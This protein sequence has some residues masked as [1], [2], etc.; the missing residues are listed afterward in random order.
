VNRIYFAGKR[1][2]QCWHDAQPIDFADIFDAAIVEP[3]NDC[4]AP[5]ESGDGWEHTFIERNKLP[6][7]LTLDD[8]REA[9]GWVRSHRDGGLI[10]VDPAVVKKQWMGEYS[11]ASGEHRQVYEERIAAVR[12][13]AVKQLVKWYTDGYE[14]WRVCCNFMDETASLGMIQDDYDGAHLKACRVEMAE[15][16]ADLLEKRGFVVIN[17]PVHPSQTQ[18]R[19]NQKRD[20]IARHMGFEDYKTYRRWVRTPCRWGD[21]SPR[22]PK[23]KR[24]WPRKDE[25]A[26]I[27]R[28]K[29][30]KSYFIVFLDPTNNRRIVGAVANAMFSSRPASL[31]S[32]NVSPNYISDNWLKRFAWDEL[33]IDWQK[34]FRAWLQV[35]PGEVR[36][37]WR[38]GSQ[39]I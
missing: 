32:T 4:E 39:P 15:D 33:P 14:Y 6:D 7:R 17:K 30:K 19:S 21:V 26:R 36:G 24:G 3:D 2:H 9:T 37:F 38:V 18:I 29:D 13:N 12:R 28:D 23:P 27:Y 31:G 10:V 11:K 8:A 20:N 16:V 5:W 35:D 25:G 1:R 22:P 34:A